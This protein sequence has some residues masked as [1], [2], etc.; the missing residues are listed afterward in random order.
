MKRV[1]F[2]R[3]IGQAGPVKIGCSVGPNKRR[4]ELETW[5]P[6]PL[7]IVAE[8][9]GGFDIER[10]FHAK[11]Q[12]T[13]ERRE[14]FTWSQGLDDTI[15]AIN[16]GAFDVSTLPEPVQITQRIVIPVKTENHRKRSEEQTSELQSL[17]RISYS[18]FCLKK[19]TQKIQRTK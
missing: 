10:R 13:H 15:T 7:E 11:F 4:H 12:D 3:P 9:D 1:Y 2:I 16:A 19:K 5:S 14:W 18:V 17:M 8:I 6:V